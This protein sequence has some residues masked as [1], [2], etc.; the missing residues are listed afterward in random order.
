MQSI[1]LQVLF[2]LLNIAFELKTEK[3]NLP[4]MSVWKLKTNC[5][6]DNS[7]DVTQKRKQAKQKK[8]KTF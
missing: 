3:C 8:F 7:K 6:R 4:K 2:V 5:N 1:I